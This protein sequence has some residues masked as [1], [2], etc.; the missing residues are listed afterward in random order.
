MSRWGGEIRRAEANDAVGVAE[1][2]AELA[3]SF[4]FERGKFLA[5]YPVLIANEDVC[6]L[7]AVERQQ[8]LGYLLGFRHLTFFANGPVGWVEEIAVHADARRLGVGA[9]LMSAFE[10]WAAASGA[11]MVALATRRA[12]PFY[13]ALG[14]EESAVYFRKKLPGSALCLEPACPANRATPRC[15]I[16]KRSQLRSTVLRNWALSNAIGSGPSALVRLVAQLA[17]FAAAAPGAADPRGQQHHQHYAERQCD[18]CGDRG[19]HRVIHRPPGKAGYASVLKQADG[20]RAE[21]LGARVDADTHPGLDDVGGQRRPA[22]E[23]G[24]RDRH[25]GT[26]AGMLRHHDADRAADHRPQDGVHEVPPDVQHRDLPCDELPGEEHG[27][28]REHGRLL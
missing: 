27:R 16:T 2:A 1:L 19:G 8:H 9:A 23:Q 18:R 17:G 15:A 12:A 24:R 7:V 20:G 3:T 28:G 13:L 21:R 5:N 6:L 26:S 11:P 10:E 25:P 14:Y 22:A 4:A